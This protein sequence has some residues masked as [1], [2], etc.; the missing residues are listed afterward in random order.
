MSGICNSIRVFKGTAKMAKSTKST[1]STESTAASQSNLNVNKLERNAGAYG[2]GPHN[3]N[4][5]NN[6]S[7]SKSKGKGKGQDKAST[8]K[9]SN[10]SKSSLSSSKSSKS[11]NSRI[12]YGPNRAEISNINNIQND[13]VALHFQERVLRTSDIRQLQ[14]P[15]PLGERL[16]TFYYAYLQFRRFKTVASEVAFLS[17]TTVQCLRNME[18]RLLRTMIREL[19]LESKN[20]ILMPLIRKGHWSL[21]MLSRPDRKCVHY[22]SRDHYND[23]LARQ[24]WDRVR[25]LLGAD[26]SPLVVG[27]CLQQRYEYE[28]GCHMM[29]MTNFAVDY[30]LRCGYASCSLLVSEDQV[31]S[32]RTTLLQLI[33][34]LGGNVSG[35]TSGSSSSSI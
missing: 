23:E 21:L 22:D 16:V 15:Y 28:A 34:S 11:S 9:S 20:F 4:N 3:N 5:N 13:P 31:G 12:S 1:K 8:N 2:D 33:Q 35:S 25:V 32:M 29:C 26:Q 27:R 7:K 14:G 30:C 19:D 24:L 18:P 17:P 6:N 10:K